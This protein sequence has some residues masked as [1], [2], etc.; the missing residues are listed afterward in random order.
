MLT[1]FIT[2]RGAI[3]TLHSTARP[4][5]AL[6]AVSATTFQLPLSPQSIPSYRATLLS[7]SLST[8]LGGNL[9]I[10]ANQSV[11]PNEMTLKTGAITAMRKFS[12]IGGPVDNISNPELY[13][14]SAYTSI[15]KLPNY[16]NTY[17]TQY[18]EV[19]HMLKSLYDEGPDGLMQV[20]LSKCGISTDQFNKKL[21]SHFQSEPKVSGI[22]PSSVSFSN[23]MV[24]C[25]QRA[26]HWKTQYG[27]QY[28]SIE[29]LLLAAAE[30]PGFGKKIFQ[31]LLGSDSVKM[32]QTG[33]DAIRGNNKV[34]TRSPE[35]AYEAL[36]KYSQD[37]TEAARQGKLDPVIGRDEEIRRTIQILSRR[38]KNNPLLLGEPG[39]GKTAIA[40]GLAQRIVNGDVPDPLKGRKL[41]S[42]DLGALLAGA[43]FR[44]EFEERLKAVLKE[45]QSAEGQ[46]VL[47]IDE[48]HMLVGAGS[49]EGSMDAGN[50]LK[51][52]LARGELRCIGATTFK[53]YK[54]YIGKDKALERRFQQ[55]H[56][57]EPSVTDT[58]SILRGLKEKYA[59]HHG[60]RITDQALIAAATL[61]K[62]YITD[63]FLPDKAVDLVDESAAKLNIQLTS[64]PQVLDDLDR[65]IIQLQMEKMSLEG[66][67]KE[68]DEK[69]TGTAT[70]ET[71]ARIQEITEQLDDLQREQQELK[72]RWD[73]ERQ[74]VNRVQELKNQIDLTVTQMEQ[75]ER[76][77]DLT[78]AGQLK[79][80]DIPRLKQELAAEELRVAKKS[81]NVA[82]ALLNDTVGESEI[83]DVVA[84][85]TGIP[86]NKLLQGDMIKLL[87]L[88]AELETRVVGQSQATKVVAEAIQ[89]SRAGLTDSSKPTASMVFLGPTGVGKTELCK[90]LANSLFDSEDAIIRIDMSEYMEK[91]SVARLIGA[92]PGYVGFEEGGQLTEAVHRRPYSVVLFDEME[93]AH[94]D[95][96]NVLLQLLDDGRLTDAKGMVVN[97]SNCIIIF[98][99]NIGSAIDATSVP[100]D[101]KEAFTMNALKASFRPE[102][103]NRIDEFVHFNPLE[104]PQLMKIVHLEVKKLSARLIEKHISLQVTDEAAKWLVEKGY[105]SA[106]GARPLKRTIQRELETPLAQ[107]ILKGTFTADSEVQIDL[108]T[109]V[110]DEAELTFSCIPNHVD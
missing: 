77:L 29:H 65:K 28:V 2:K 36:K 98:T 57:G 78:R 92:P 60:V 37:L 3:G 6:R 71:M 12:T 45:V 94:P 23:A 33:I 24:A 90:T 83:A 56:V 21:T 17:Q 107:G 95:V 80:G 18:V 34:T 44:G 16:A 58:I 4:I 64:K 7:K 101:E 9:T 13:T 48:L 106:Y 51:P 75:A 32:L 104:L 91:H 99:S 102:F 46:I 52:M 85:W 96:F 35:N 103:L 108:N 63:R 86:V 97:F 43:K 73:L 110:G 105:D 15:A 54:Q 38:T 14:E 62:R 47:F 20:I 1:R 50:L 82:P 89:R 53:E 19:P 26:V 31:D 40:E 25:L 72:E 68:K 11:L 49:S 39:V 74:G 55:V 30:S 88:Q 70:A 61:S 79:Y 27:D 109:G 41:V 81:E 42:L 93:K 84:A 67:S 22:S 100:A 5:H 59:V 69:S 66:D 10:R 76:Q 8:T 87:G